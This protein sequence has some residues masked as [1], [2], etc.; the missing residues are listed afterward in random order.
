MQTQR[1]CLAVTFALQLA[2]CS[3]EELPL[4]ARAESVF[5]SDSYAGRNYKL[6]VPSSYS[7]GHALPLVLMLH[8]CT[9]DPAGFATGTAMN[10]LAE[11]QGFFALYPEQP[12]SANANKCWQW[13]LPAHQAR[14]SGEPANLAD[15]V[16]HI[17]GS[18]S[19][20]SGRVYAAGLSS[21]AAMTVILGATYPDVFAAISV[22]SGLEYKAA[23]GSTVDAYSAM[24]SGGP[25]PVTQGRL[26][27]HAMGASPKTVPTLVFHGSSDTTVA[28]VNGNQI[29]SQWAKTNDLASDGAEDGNITDTPDSTVSSTVSG[30]R[31]YTTYSY[32]DRTT[33]TVVL[34]KILVDGMGHAWSGG[35]SAGTY[36]DPKGPDAS[37]L[38]WEFFRSHARGAAPP[39]PPVDA[40]VIDASQPPDLSTPDLSTPDLHAAD[41]AAP[42]LSPPPAGHTL[43]SIDAEDGFVGAVVA[44]GTSAAT[45]K[46]GDKGMFNGDTY[47]GILSFDASSLPAGKPTGAQLVLTRRS[48]SGSVSAL[49]VDVK[50]GSFGSSPALAQGDYSAAATV[51]GV[52]TIVPP[53]RDGASVTVSLP[54]AALAAIGRG[55]RIQ[56]RLRATTPVDFPSD[57][58]EL[59]DGSSAA[60]APTLIVTY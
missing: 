11:S 21:G 3:H 15:L 44:D 32:R 60:Y 55:D 38:S 25:S 41:A 18:Y 48:Q 22:G 14:G 56:L 23:S 40:G 57:V 6:Y 10:T 34:Q 39:P 54:P 1:V 27:Y 7:A 8:G 20:D 29:L 26:A 36:T 47:R 5:V 50:S 12:S 13:W 16:H 30:G 17:A 45:L 58:I 33:G 53:S 37:A 28:P 49:L 24:S 4:G 42:D 19:V 59:Y 2:A 46:V 9:Q 52:T 35:S 31:K 51:T 43:R